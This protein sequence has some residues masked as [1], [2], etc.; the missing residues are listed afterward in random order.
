MKTAGVIGDNTLQAV[1]EKKLERSHIFRV[2]LDFLYDGLTRFIAFL[3]PVG[4]ELKQRRDEKEGRGFPSR[5]FRFHFF[6]QSEHFVFLLVE[7]QVVK[8]L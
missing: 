5:A 2:L 1:K 4:N 3:I 7:K 8:L 6:Q